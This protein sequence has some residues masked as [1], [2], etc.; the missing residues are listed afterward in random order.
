MD[1]LYNFQDDNI[2]IRG[3]IDKETILKY[4]TEE[5]IFESIL[6][7]EPRE[8]DYIC[9]PLRADKNPGAFFQRG[10]FSN[11]LLFVD[12]ADPFKTHY[13]CFDFIQR[14]YKLSNFYLTLTFVRDSLINGKPIRKSIIEKN[15]KGRVKKKIKRV[16]IHIEARPFN[17][18]DGLYWNKYGIKKRH[19]IEDRVFAVSRVLL[20][21]SRRG[22]REIPLYTKCF[23]F[24]DFEDGRKKL[25]YPYSKGKNRFLSTCIK[26]DIMT[27]H[28]IDVTQ[29]MI[30]KSYKDYRV[31]RNLGV[32]VTW[33]QNEGSVPNN[34]KKIINGYK[35]VI[36]FFD[37]DYTG[38]EASEKLV[39]IIGNKAREIYLP[40]PLLEEGIKDASDMYLKKGVDELKLFLTKNKINLYDKIRRDS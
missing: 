20:K 5:E 40:I 29:L 2:E 34:L 23:A 17:H 13:D 4:I 27:K 14:Y 18:T 25:Y 28:L 11:K 1:T 35:D 22:N 24:T 38:L 10:L 30:T 15:T 21:N 26:E 3:Y 8:F 19:L 16:E 9:S 31:L 6:G 33:F 37:N 7:F 32:N 12:W 39:D 36:I